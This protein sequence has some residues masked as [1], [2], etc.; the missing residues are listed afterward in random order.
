M[1]VGVILGASMIGACTIS[2]IQN[3]QE[4]TGKS[5]PSVIV[6]NRFEANINAHGSQ[7]DNAWLK[8]FNDTELNELVI[9][10]L[11]NNADI[12]IMAA[13]RKQAESLIDAAGGTQYPGINAIGNMGSK[14]GSSGSGITGYYIGANWELDL[15][16]RVRSSVA[17][18]EQNSRA[19][20]ADQ[21]A[22]RLSLIATIAKSVWFARHLQDQSNLA[23]ENA[24]AAYKYAELMQTR[25]MVGAASLTEVS[26]ALASAAQSKEAAIIAT[27]TRDQSLRAV[28]VLIGRYPKAQPLKTTLLPALPPPVSPGLPTDLLE[29]RP[30]LIAAEARVNSAFYLADE[31]RLAR[32]PKI[33]LTAGF[34]YINSQIFSLINSS[35]TSFGAG[36]NAA[37][38]LFQGGAI[39][40]QIAYQNAEAQASLANYGKTVLLAF[41]DVENALTG[42]ASW[43]ERSKQ[44]EIQFNEQ[45]RVMQNTRAELQIGRIDQ[46]QVQQQIIKTN[47]SEMSWR[48]GKVEA[49]AQRVNLYL[50]LGGSAEE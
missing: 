43:R 24:L 32:L 28:E 2:K 10:A 20:N 22:A 19:I 42:E 35:N 1:M 25:E 14:V 13:R 45:K 6:P 36:A 41:N 46:R 16:G 8:Q 38:P 15:W 33:S 44:L 27:Q 26:T 48:Q 40:A 34:G 23:N 12:R 50:S 49:L 39:E 18:A 21:D 31:K 7:I 3:S 29:R 37:I 4:L 11:N 47:I 17:S 9:E 5:L 30:D